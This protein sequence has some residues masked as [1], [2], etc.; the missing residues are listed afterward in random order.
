[1]GSYCI[2]LSS[3]RKRKVI[4]ITPT[5]TMSHH[6]TPVLL[7][8]NTFGN[9]GRQ[10]HDLQTFGTV[11]RHTRDPLRTHR[12]TDHPLDQ[13]RLNPMCHERFHHVGSSWSRHAAVVHICPFDFKVWFIDVHP[14]VS[15]CMVDQQSTHQ[16]HLLVFNPH[17]GACRSFSHV[18]VK[19]TLVVVVVVVVR[20]SGRLSDSIIS[21]CT[22]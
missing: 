8:T 5:H 1:M 12:H 6:S 9:G 16:D 10:F 2:R 20:G 14:H 4:A 17:C 11:E 22:C 3:N 19:V 15:Y 7:L 13:H 18:V 21:R